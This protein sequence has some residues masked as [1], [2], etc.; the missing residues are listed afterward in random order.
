MKARLVTRMMSFSTSPSMLIQLLKV[1]SYV[2]NLL[3]L[4]VYYQ[5]Q[6]YSLWR[7]MIVILKSSGKMVQRI[8][9]LI[10]LQVEILKL[11]MAD[12]GNKHS[13]SM[14]QFTVRLILTMQQRFGN[15]FMLSI[16]Q[17][18]L[19]LGTTLLS[20]ILLSA[21]SWKNSHCGRGQ[22]YIHKCGL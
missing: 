17:P 14:R 5:N 19:M 3:I 13:V 7:I 21:N 8:F 4:I 12:V 16:R 18:N 9:C 22:K 2:R 1:K 11:I 6:R 10:P 15:M 20:T